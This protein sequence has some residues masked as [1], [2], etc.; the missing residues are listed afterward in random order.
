MANAQLKEELARLKA[1]VADQRT[2]SASWC[3]TAWPEH[4]APIPMIPWMPSTEAPNM[5][6]AC[7]WAQPGMHP[8]QSVIVDST[9]SGSSLAGSCGEVDLTDDV[10]TTVI[11][12]QLPTEFSRDMLVAVLDKNG[13][14]RSYDFVYIPHNFKEARSFGYAFVNFVDAAVAESFLDRATGFAEWE[15]KAVE[16]SW[17]ENHQG[18][19][20]HID[21]YRNSAV[22]HESVR[23]EFK[24]ALFHQ[25]ER[26]PFPKPTKTIKAPMRQ[27]RAE[28]ERC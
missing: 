1:M 13:F 3:A 22:M 19:D 20:A 27:R 17:S 26:V 24:P 16:V 14:E 11:V 23:E 15:S 12:K 5:R 6:F 28:A 10:N 8:H 2:R 7:G 21:R 9:A 4:C 18:I 25:G